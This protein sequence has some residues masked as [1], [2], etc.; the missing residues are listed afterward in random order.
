MI[1]NNQKVN[2]DELEHFFPDIPST[3]KLKSTMNWLQNI[4]QS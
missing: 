3:N 1:C 4:L 2:V